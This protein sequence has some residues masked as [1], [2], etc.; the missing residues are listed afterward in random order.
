[1]NKILLSLICDKGIHLIG[2]KK[3]IHKKS[4]KNKNNEAQTAP[5]KLIF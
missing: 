4:A 3:Y 5:G 2:T 1:M